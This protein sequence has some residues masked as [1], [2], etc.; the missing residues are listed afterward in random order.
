[1]LSAVMIVMDEEVCIQRAIY[2]I[3]AYVDEIIVV[4][5]GSTDKTKEIASSFEKVRLY[6]VP[7]DPAGGDRFDVQRNKSLEFAKGEWRLMIDADEYYDPHVM[8]AIPWLMQPESLGLPANTDA[9][10]FSRRTI[11]DG[12]LV[13]PTNMDWQIRLFGHRCR[14]S[15]HV[16]ESVTGY[17]FAVFTNLHIMHDK[18]AAWQQKDNELY[19]DMGGVPPEGWVKEEGIWTWKG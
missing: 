9:Y 7:F 14:Y 1:M 2:S 5:G 16:S 19:W 17:S 12:R 4:D 3:C 15:G 8:D 18:E 6:E 11:I 13:N 10:H